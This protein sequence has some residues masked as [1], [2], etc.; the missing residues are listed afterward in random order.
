LPSSFFPG[1]SSKRIFPFTWKIANAVAYSV[2]FM[3]TAGRPAAEASARL[4][5]QRA[6]KNAEPV[7]LNRAI[8]N[9]VFYGMLL[10]LGFSQ[11]RK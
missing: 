6:Y 10:P 2:F 8:K 9:R 5:A 3:E 7:Y 11:Q 4:S 1:L